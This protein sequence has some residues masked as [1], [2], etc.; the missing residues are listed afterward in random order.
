L[1]RSLLLTLCA[2]CALVVW[3]TRAPA[4]GNKH[5]APARPTP[6][7]FE[8]TE[9]LV[10][11]GE[12]SKAILRGI[13]IAEFHFTAAHT[14]ANP[15]A[16]NTTTEPSAPNLIFKG[17]ATAKGWFRKLFHIDFHF[18]ME[19]LVE[20]QTFN[21]LRTTTRDEQGQRIRL[22]EA[23]FDRSQNLI[24]W[25]ERNPNDPASQPRVVQRPLNDATYDVLSAIYYLRTR[26]LAPG[27][28]LELALSDS[29]QIFHVP[30]K[31]GERKRMKTVLGKVQT[32]RLDVELFGP[33]RLINDRQGRMSLWLTD[34]ARRIPVRAHFDTS[35][36][37]LD[38][39]L[40]KVVSAPK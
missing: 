36:G 9:E 33:N 7:P 10:Y 34:D 22:S 28:T 11:E 1:R 38:I 31:V 6:L 35:D 26:Q 5:D 27:Q 23:V 15:T 20:P 19:S 37:A 4:H 29:G 30:I 21:I 14:P 12:F 40:K 18:Q 16:T 13:E 2:L 24:T 17:D 3:P 8:P 32:L 39:K 25:T